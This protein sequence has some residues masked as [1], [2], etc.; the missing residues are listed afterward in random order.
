MTR[1]L[2]QALAPVLIATA[3][4]LALLVD[5]RPGNSAAAFWSSNWG[6]PGGPVHDFVARLDWPRAESSNQSEVA[7]DGAD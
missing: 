5:E 7:A 4:S 2:Q 6:M 1:L 3:T